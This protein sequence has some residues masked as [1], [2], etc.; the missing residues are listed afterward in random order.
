MVFLR[1]H[2]LIHS[3][4]MRTV[5]YFVI[6]PYSEI[7]NTSHV[8]IL[9]APVV[10]DPVDVTTTY[11]SEL[12]DSSD[13]LV[14]YDGTPIAMVNI[15]VLLTTLLDVYDRDDVDD[16]MELNPTL[17]LTEL[18]EYLSDSTV[19][20]DVLITTLQRIY[21][22]DTVRDLMQENPTFTLSDLITALYRYGAR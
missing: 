6:D 14:Y 21:G 1:D 3:E 22:H 5:P 8:D 4:Q 9:E 20:I 12:I 11:D 15:H 10:Y 17:S 18:I 7:S 19:H 13:V 16:L 2:I